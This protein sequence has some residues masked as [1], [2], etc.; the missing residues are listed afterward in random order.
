MA[1]V[2]KSTIWHETNSLALNVC[3][4]QT[5][6]LHEGDDEG[7]EGK[8]A[9]VIPKLRVSTGCGAPSHT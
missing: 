3:K 8:G 4:D 7:A 6:Y 5:N 1:Q 2:S 9:K